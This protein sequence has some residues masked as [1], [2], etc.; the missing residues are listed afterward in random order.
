M[1]KNSHKNNKTYKLLHKILMSE[2]NTVSVEEA[3]REAEE[4]FKD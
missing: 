3:L 4:K 1:K 2:D